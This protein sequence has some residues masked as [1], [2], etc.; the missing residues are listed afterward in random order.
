MRGGTKR[1]AAK[2]ETNPITNHRYIDI[3]GAGSMN[4]RDGV[5]KPHTK[6]KHLEQEQR[7]DVLGRI[8][9]LVT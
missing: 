9:Y 8:S 6:P 7:N 3:W 2:A 1:S 5:K 4:P